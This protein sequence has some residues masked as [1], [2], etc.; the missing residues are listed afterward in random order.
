[1]RKN[2]YLNIIF[3]NNYIK[4]DFKTDKKYKILSFF[5]SK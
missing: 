5:I 2:L 3:Y 4:K 1:M